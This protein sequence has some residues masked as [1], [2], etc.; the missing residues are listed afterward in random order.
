[1]TGAVAAFMMSS[2]V[3]PLVRVYDT[4]TAATETIP[5][6][7]SQVIIE[8]WGAGGGG[9]NGDAGTPARGGGG[10]SGGYVK[11]TYAL[12][13]ANW[14]QTFTYSVGAGGSATP[15]NGGN[16]SV[17]NGTFPTATSLAAGGGHYGIDGT[18]STTQGAGG[19]ASGGD[20]NT[21]GNGGAATSGGAIAPNAITQT[22]GGG[23]AG[24]P[25]SGGPGQPGTNGRVQFSYT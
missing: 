13:S 10:G 7:Y 17:T 22:P 16:T 23:G 15:T 18:I 9:G 1:M 12:T 6:G 11:K 25:F 5:S 19:T 14:G 3:Q 20:V 21:P 4:G 2:G 8:T 24:G